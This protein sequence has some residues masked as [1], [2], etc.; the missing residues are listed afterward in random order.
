M[1]SAEN[2]SG[3]VRGPEHDQEIT[4]EGFQTS[5]GK[6]VLNM[7]VFKNTSYCHKSVKCVIM[8]QH[9]N[10]KRPQIQTLRQTLLFLNLC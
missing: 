9:S 2:F 3:Y 6:L 4:R 5:G 7:G 10:L 8:F 1:C